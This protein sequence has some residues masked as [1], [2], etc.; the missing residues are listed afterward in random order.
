ML[1]KKTKHIESEDDYDYYEASEVWVADFG[2]HGI[3]NE[4][5]QEVLKLKPLAPKNFSWVLT[6]IIL[7]L[8]VVATELAIRY[9]ASTSFWTEGT[10]SIITWIWRVIFVTLW[11]YLANVKWHLPKEKMF[12][13]TFSAFVLGILI[14]AIFKIVY[15]KSAWAWLNLFVEPIWMI[16]IIALLGSL[17]VKFRKN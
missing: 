17:F 16:L 6:A 3:E 7:L 4:L 9:I 1:L 12:V 2:S 11:F 8:L 15:I 14:L 13:S 10:I 5:K